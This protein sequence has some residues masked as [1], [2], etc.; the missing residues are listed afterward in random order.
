[1]A[2]TSTPTLTRPTPA[3]HLPGSAAHR[4]CR[5]VGFAV[6]GA[7]F[8]AYAV[9]AVSRHL[10]IRTT[11]Y[12]LGIFEQAVRG[13]AHLRAPV[14]ELKGPHFNLLGDHFH[15]ILAL[16]GPVYHVFPGPYTLLVAQAALLALSALPAEAAP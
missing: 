3:Q 13:Y 1:M 2:D 9:L 7:L 6:A 16:L 15:P 8:C 11:G 12:D 14:S 4:P 5:S 10:Q